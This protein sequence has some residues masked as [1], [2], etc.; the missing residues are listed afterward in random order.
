MR[1]YKDKNFASTSV[2]KR[3]FLLRGLSKGV[4]IGLLC[5]MLSITVL[6]LEGW[7][8]K[9]KTYLDHSAPINSELTASISF[10]YQTYTNYPGAG[11]GWTDFPSSP[12]KWDIQM[13]MTNEESGVYTVIPIFLFNER[14]KKDTQWIENSMAISPLPY[15]ARLRSEVPFP[16]RGVPEHAPGV[17]SEKVFLQRTQHSFP[18]SK[19]EIGGFYDVMNMRASLQKAGEEV[20]WRRQAFSPKNTL[21][22][23]WDSWS[24]WAFPDHIRQMKDYNVSTL[25]PVMIKTGKNAN[26][27]FFPLVEYVPGNPKDFHRLNGKDVHFIELTTSGI[28]SIEK[29][30]PEI[31]AFLHA[32]LKELSEK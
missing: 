19:E 2:T 11:G 12:N 5:V 1:M 13:H 15:Q 22:F 9:E 21:N 32:L 17:V 20:G 10:E 8:G 7:A 14:Y 6:S 29:S 28:E 30:S 18:P 25:G 26:H 31:H 4:G 27:A 3:L 23:E 16:V 24:G